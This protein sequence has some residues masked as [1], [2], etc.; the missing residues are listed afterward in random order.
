MRSKYF[1]TSIS[2]VFLCAIAHFAQGIPASY[3]A[4][5]RTVFS[6]LSR[7]VLIRNAHDGS[8]RLFIVEQTGKIKVAQ[9]GSSATSVF[10]DLSSKSWNPSGPGDERGFVGLA[11]HPQFAENGKFYV[12]YVRASDAATVVAE[13]TTTT[14]NGA[15][16][17]GDISSE[18]IL[19][20][21]PQ[22][23]AYHHGGMLEFGP[24]GY[25]YIST[26]DG[27]PGDDPGARAQN[28]AI[29]LGKML[30][31][32]VDVPAGSTE[33]YLIPP[34]NPFTGAGTIRCDT[35][36]TGVGKVCREIWAT[37]FRNPWRYSFDRDTGQMWVADVGEGVFEEV[38]VITSG[39]GNYG[40]RVYE[41]DQ[42]TSLDPD[43]CD[44]SNYIFP[45]FTY[46]HTEGRCAITGGYV[47]RG[48][49]G[50]LPTGA[51]VYA[52]YCTGE[53]WMRENDR[54]VLLAD[55]PR[56]IY[57]FGEDEDG[58]IYVCYSNGQI[59]KI[60]RAHAA[61]DLDGDLKTDV[62]IYRPS[63]G[64][65]Y[66]INS[67]NGSFRIQQFGIAE[68]IPALEDYDGDNI[69][70]IA[71]FR[72]S[73]GT[74]YYIRSSD[75]TV[76]II[77][78]GLS[79]DKPQA[80]DYDGDGKADL[81]VYRP[82]TGFWYTLRS[83]DGGFSAIQFGLS[84][85][86]PTAADFDGDGKTDIALWRPTE[87]TW[88]W[89][90]SSNGAFNAIPFGLAGDVPAPGDY[91]GDGK[92]DPTV[93]RPS[94]GTWFT[95]Q[96]ADGSVPTIKWGLSEDIPVAGDYDGDGIADIAVFRPST[97]V[98]YILRSTDRGL[99]SAQFGIST[100]LPVPKYDAP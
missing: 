9:P 96:S 62:S 6:G 45:S 61:A 65:W 78:F 80:G 40:W 95:L 8:K 20:T 60:S 49:L 71:V 88:Y 2:L 42:C 14:G 57:S 66:A 13:Y 48:T 3:T 36:G 22:P 52:D 72:P 99:Q 35:G 32:D 90:N 73:T 98:W 68:D 4:R 53:I 33:Q 26:G 83:S 5:L 63:T 87:G 55:T 58:E 19:L 30:R 27:G 29:L 43:L 41:G 75:N 11:F 92:T 51:Y 31:I 15:S 91:D 86:I 38:D 81:T 74:W 25:L 16:D 69:S 84:A 97:G 7:P 10:M 34:T 64:V 12:D 93:F 56:A 59:D 70:D 76:A 28:K 21:I 1:T 37:G 77:Q 89:L 44:P 17:Q 79:G 94:S 85:D 46:P 39:G 23:T 18:R 54:S 82:S 100:D 50:S 24:D 67:S 47:Y